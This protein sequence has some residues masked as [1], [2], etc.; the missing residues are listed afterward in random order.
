MEKF[1]LVLIHF[2]VLTDLLKVEPHTPTSEPVKYDKKDGQWYAHNG[3]DVQDTQQRKGK[4][5]HSIILIVV[6]RL[7]MHK[8]N[9]LSK[10]CHI[11][12]ESFV[13]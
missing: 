7:C 13:F 8:P 2:T 5:N 3:V 6:M 4:N 12:F 9:K 11:V 1:H 10:S